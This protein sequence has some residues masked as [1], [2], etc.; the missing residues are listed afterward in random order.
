[1]ENL[2]LMEKTQTETGEAVLKNNLELKGFSV[3]M[4]K[5]QYELKKFILKY[6]PDERSVGLDGSEIITE[7]NIDLYLVENFN[8]LVDP[9]NND[10]S[11]EI[12]DYLKE[13]LAKVDFYVTQPDAITMDGKVIFNNKNKFL[14]ESNITKPSKIYA[15]AKTN[16]IVK[17]VKE[18]ETRLKSKELTVLEISPYGFKK[19]TIDNSGQIEEFK[20]TG[21]ETSKREFFI[22]LMS[23]E[24][25]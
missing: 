16:S 11:P 8:V 2:D 4:I 10:I 13:K 3:V 19:R 17:D 14:L 6:I 5:N 9:F 15:F 7:N 24:Y 18:A 21:P 25:A 22:V 23:E 12:Q 20:E 1:M